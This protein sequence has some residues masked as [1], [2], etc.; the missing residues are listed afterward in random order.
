[1]QTDFNEVDGDCWLSRQ[2]VK[3][4]RGKLQKLQKITDFVEVPLVFR[5]FRRSCDV[6]L[7]Y[8]G[9]RHF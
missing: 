5:T 8:F 7:S 3:F 1:M 2:I 4:V 9:I 6:E